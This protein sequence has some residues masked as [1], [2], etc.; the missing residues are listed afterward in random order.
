MDANPPAIVE[1]F[2]TRAEFEA[3]RSDVDSLHS[4]LDHLIELSKLNAE[5]LDWLVKAEKQEQAEAD[6][7]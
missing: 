6:H 1:P 5:A 3:L 2:V 7:G 4:K